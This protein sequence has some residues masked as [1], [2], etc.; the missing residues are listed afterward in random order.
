MADLISIGFQYTGGLDP[1]VRDTRLAKEGTESLDNSIKLLERSEK[2]AE[3]VAGRLALTLREKNNVLRA[4][5]DGNTDAIIQIKQHNLQQR[6]LAQGIKKDSI[7]ALLELNKQNLE[8]EQT[9]K[10]AAQA[11]RGVGRATEASTKELRKNSVRTAQASVQLEQ[12]LNQ[13]QGGANP[14]LAFSQQA[15]DLGIVLGF[16]LAGA[17]AGITGA[18]VSF[19]GPAV[20]DL[21]DKTKVLEDANNEL[22]KSFKRTDEGAVQLTDRFKELNSQSENLARLALVDALKSAKDAL[23]AAD[24]AAEDFSDSL[25]VLEQFSLFGFEFG[26]SQIETITQQLSF[27]GLTAEEAFLKI[28]NGEQ[29]SNSNIARLLKAVREVEGAFGLGTEEALKLGDALGA[30]DDGA[31]PNEI[32]KLRD[33]LA[34]VSTTSDLNNMEFLKLFQT[35][36]NLATAAE[37]V[38]EALKLTNG[39]LKDG[40][41]VSKELTSSQQSLLDSLD[42][43]TALSLIHI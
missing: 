42:P 19:L 33:V 26:L 38:Q 17:I 27:M 43:L 6:L 2:Q 39:T 18:L 31:T 41:S 12:F 20:I 36:L 15:A 29:N 40:I 8:L 10:A 28:Q 1:L 25:D 7:K 13:I 16:G 32:F 23:N 9:A 14:L 22:Q 4:T 34:E 3:K 37:N 30:L 35:T 21:T 24:E 11:Q 5:A